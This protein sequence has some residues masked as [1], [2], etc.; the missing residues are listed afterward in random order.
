MGFCWNIL[1]FSI[2]GDVR[3]SWHYP[4]K[5]LLL[6]KTINLSSRKGQPSGVQVRWALVPV[7]QFSFWHQHPA[8]LTIG[9][10]LR[11]QTHI[12]NPNEIWA[13]V[14]VLLKFNLKLF[15]FILSWH[16]ACFFM[17]IILIV[18]WMVGEFVFFFFFCHGL[19]F[20]FWQRP[21]SVPSR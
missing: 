2:R 12:T 6:T 16:F 4:L 8:S 19:V 18:W 21:S 15:K 7:V 9:E 11:L 17:K 10:S 20:W 13:L 3:V 5:I 1:S 14:S